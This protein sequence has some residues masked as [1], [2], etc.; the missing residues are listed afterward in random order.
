MFNF[1]KKISPED[2]V[3]PVTGKMIPLDEVKDEVFASKMMGE[4]VA[5]ELS[6]DTISSPIEG[7]VSMIANTLHAVGIKS[8][9]GAEILIHIGLNTVNLDGEGFEKLISQGDQVKKGTPLLRVD[10]TKLSELDI[11]LTTPMIVTNSNE[12]EVSI[13][14]TVDV[15]AGSTKVIKL[16]RK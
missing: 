11:I 10:R 2:L 8:N 1:F 12:F 7:E 3:S 5:F 4:G 6:D 16:V 9:R 13:N 14:T 15:E